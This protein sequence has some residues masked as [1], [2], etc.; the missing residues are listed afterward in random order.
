VRYVD[1]QAKEPMQL[2]RLATLTKRIN[3]FKWIF[4][5]KRL[6]V[7]VKLLDE[8]INRNRKGLED[9]SHRALK[10]EKERDDWMRA[11]EKKAKESQR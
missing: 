9:W 3:M 8:E 2:F 10:A 1:R 7:R 5:L 4:E 6:R 11:F